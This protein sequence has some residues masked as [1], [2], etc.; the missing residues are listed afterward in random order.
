MYTNSCYSKYTQS[1]IFLCK[2]LNII[3]Q[4]WQK[5]AAVDEL[6]GPRM[7]SRF[8]GLFGLFGLFGRFEASEM[9]PVFRM[10]ITA[11]IKTVLA[12]GAG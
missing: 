4:P 1:G 9:L 7:V 11:A 6:E 5:I 3:W 10:V 12:L 2:N 8:C